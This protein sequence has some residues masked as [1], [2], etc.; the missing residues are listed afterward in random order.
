MHLMFFSLLFRPTLDVATLQ[1][2]NYATLGYFIFDF[3]KIERICLGHD[4]TKV[5]AGWFVE[6]LRLFSKSR[7]E[8]CLFTVN[9]WFDKKEDDKKIERELVPTSYAKGKVFRMLY[10]CYCSSIVLRNIEE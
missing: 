9:R 7:N 8:T 4:G 5:G 10:T 3:I 1:L 2:V 6:D